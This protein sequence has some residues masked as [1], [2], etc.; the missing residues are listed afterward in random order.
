MTCVE[1]CTCD[2]ACIETC[3]SQMEQICS[4]CQATIRA[5]AEASCLDEAVECAVDALGVGDGGAGGVQGEGGAGSV[6]TCADLA[7]CCTRLTDTAQSN[8]ETVHA[9]V[10]DDTLCNLAWDTLGC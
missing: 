8:C 9:S 4:D 5:C 6:H 3:S 7:E 10:S 2:S 1:A